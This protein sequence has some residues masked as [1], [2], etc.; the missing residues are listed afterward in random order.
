[1]VLQKRSEY[2]NGDRVAA[3]IDGEE[4]TLKEYR[5]DGKGV[6]LIPHNP[7]LSPTCYSPERIQVQGLLI[8]VMRSC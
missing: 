2:R 1:V 5:R 8:G 6:W 3:L 4:A 7:E